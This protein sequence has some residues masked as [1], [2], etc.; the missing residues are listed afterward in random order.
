MVDFCMEKF[1]SLA[2]LFGVAVDNVACGW[3]IYQPEI[4]DGMEELVSEIFQNK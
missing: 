4:P 1:I 3:F 2:L